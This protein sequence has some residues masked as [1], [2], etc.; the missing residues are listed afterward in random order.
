MASALA[1]SMNSDIPNILI[2]GGSVVAALCDISHTDIDI[3]VVS[4]PEKG[5][6]CLRHIFAAVQRH[7]AK[8]GITK[9]L[10]GHQI[11]ARSH[12]LPL[13]ST[14]WRANAANHSRHP[15]FDRR[16]AVWI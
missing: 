4:S 12:V 3:F 5:V 10:L 1:Y 6:A 13:V 11:K 14:R 15:D 16:P 8:K 2:A 9:T 7:H